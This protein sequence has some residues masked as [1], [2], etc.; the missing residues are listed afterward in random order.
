MDRNI[1]EYINQV[2]DYMVVDDRM[3]DRV[4]K[5]LYSHIAEAYEGSTIDTIIEKMGTPEEVAKEF[6]DSIYEDKEQVIDRLVK[7]RDK[8]RDYSKGYYEYKSKTT[9]FGLPLVHINT[10]SHRMVKSHK[11]SFTPRVAKGIIA[12]GDISIGVISLGGIAMG[13]LSLGGL[14]VGLLALG[15]AALG[16]LS[17]GGV[18]IGI[19]A[20]GGLAAGFMSM[21][22]AAIGNVAIG[23]YARGTVAIGERAHGQYVL[24]NSN[25]SSQETLNLIKNA[26]PRLS[27]WLVKILKFFTF[28]N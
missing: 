6:M 5:D 11:H 17:L 4:W 24:Q 20:C 19:L 25:I 3:K 13:G 28:I 7:E 23:G 22:G 12:I 18:A 21:G 8:Y 16:L 27:D 1:E 15:G 26:Y 10:R 9:L 2:L 14:S